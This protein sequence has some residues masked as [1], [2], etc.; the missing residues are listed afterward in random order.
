MDKYRKSAVPIVLFL[1]PAFLIYTILEVVPIIQTFYFSFYE[2]NGIGGVALKFVGIEN[3]T[4]LMGFKG[5]WLSIK[6]VIW[7]LILS[8]F[9]Q[10]PIGFFLAILLS[11][12]CKGYRIF[13]AAFFSPL[14]LSTTAVGLMWYFILFPG[15]GVLNTIL[16]SIGMENFT[17]SWLTDKNTA[18]NSLILITAWISSGYYLTIGFAAISSIPDEIMEAGLIDGADGIKKVFYITLPLIWESVKISVILVI[19]GILK[20]FE[21]VFVMTQ[22]GPNGLTEVPVSLMYNEA[23]KYGHYGRGSAIAVIVFLMSVFITI[24]SLK[25]MQR[26]SYDE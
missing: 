1:L 2:W 20:I 6:N 5:F 10:I 9:T 8:L 4:D 19:T 7:F 13:K 18:L 25:L 12:Y 16:T 21:I 3:F 22:G 14:V 23:F 11:T 26:K 17:T 24:I 15:T